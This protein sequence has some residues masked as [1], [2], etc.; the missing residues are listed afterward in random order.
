MEIKKAILKLIRTKPYIPATILIV[1]FI[2]LGAVSSSFN[3]HPWLRS[4]FTPSPPTP[5]PLYDDFHLS[6]PSLDINVPVIA[7]VDG[8]DQTAYN[9]ALEGGVAQ[10]LGSAKPGEG[11]NIFI[12]GHSS[13]YWY[14]PGDYKKIFATLDKLK[15]G[16]EI[17]IWYN[18][19]E[20]KY[21]VSETKIVRPD[22]VDVLKPTTQ[23]QVSLMT[24][25]PP[26]TI[27]K[28]LIVIGK[29]KK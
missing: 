28:R 4:S 26:N 21:S 5:I 29:L 3:Y 11:S 14:K 25:W 20:Y 18:K 6:I 9:K 1:L 10:L 27:L 8:A 16:D 13:Y 19:K 12:F 24:C 7:D 15:E 22:E 17:I 2:V 23:E